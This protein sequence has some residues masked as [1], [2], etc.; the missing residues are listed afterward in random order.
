MYLLASLAFVSAAAAQAICGFN[1]GGTAVKRLE[2]QEDYEREFNKARILPGTDP[3]TSARLFTTIQA[4]TAN[5]PTQAIPAAIATQTSLLLGLWASAGQDA[6]NNELT[7]L[8]RA[9]EQYGMILG[10][11]ARSTPCVDEFR[12]EVCGPDRGYLSR[13]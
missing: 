11:Y 4:H 10:R 3:F 5:D 12:P 1:Y 8:K 6:F 13:V 9:I 7:A 2:T